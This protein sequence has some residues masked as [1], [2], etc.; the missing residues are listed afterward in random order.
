MTKK[1]TVLKDFAALKKLE[2]QR[3]DIIAMQIYQVVFKG[4]REIAFEPQQQK[5]LVHRVWDMGKLTIRQQQGWHM[6]N[7]DIAEAQ[8][9]SGGVSSGYGEMHDGGERTF[10]PKA[11]VNEAYRRLEALER[12]FL[13]RREKALLKDLLRNAMQEGH[14]LKLE[15]IGLV[16]SGYAGKDSAYV[17]GVVH[18]QTL[19]DRLADYYGY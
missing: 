19:L 14:E 2:Q 18:T 17:A 12:G 15:H 10:I 8:G 6:L 3:L 13:S 9:K 5:S 16:R 7:K 11:Y 1:Q 4:D